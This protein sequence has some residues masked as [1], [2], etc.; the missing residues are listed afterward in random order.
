MKADNPL[1]KHV[2]VDNTKMKVDNPLAKHV[3]VD[4]TKIKVRN[5]L[6]KHAAPASTMS[7]W[8]NLLNP[9]DVK[10]AALASTMPTTIW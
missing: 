3:P 2:P 9:L 7:R 5:P 8:D 1:A 6:A 4:N 10:I